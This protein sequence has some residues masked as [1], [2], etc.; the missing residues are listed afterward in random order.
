V[1]TVRSMTDSKAVGEDA[2]GAS[3]RA[4]RRGLIR[5]AAL[6]MLTAASAAIDYARA[7]CEV[8][9]RELARSRRS[10]TPLSLLYV[11]LDEVLREGDVAARIGGDEF[12]DAVMYEAKNSGKGRLA[13]EVA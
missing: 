5:A 11:D 8:L 9:N 13:A 3:L 2:S 6:L 4:G 7:V 10:G 12:A 1:H